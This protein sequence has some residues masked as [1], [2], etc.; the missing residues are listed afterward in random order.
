M[1]SGD[2]ATVKE[3]VT[4]HAVTYPKGT[5]VRI[6]LVRGG[7]GTLSVRVESGP[8]KDKTFEARIEKFN[9]SKGG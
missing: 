6:I 7:Y 4:V 3:P 5:K 1:K 2:L 8:L 9:V